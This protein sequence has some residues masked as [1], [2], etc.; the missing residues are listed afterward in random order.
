MKSA[1]K[2]PFTPLQITLTASCECS[3][4]RCEQAM[5]KVHDALVR[6]EHPIEQP[7]RVLDKL[8]VRAV[9]LGERLLV[10]A[11]HH[12]L[13][14]GPE[15][16]QAER[17]HV[18]DP[19]LPALGLLERHARLAALRMR[20]GVDAAL[21]ARVLGK[22]RGA[23]ARRGIDEVEMDEPPVPPSRVITP[24]NATS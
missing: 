12:H 24:S 14:L 16:F 8:Q 4:S 13:R 11:L 22:F 18:L 10:L 20:H 21:V 3:D 7:R 15:P 23:R 1:V 5:R 17:V 2:P 9:Q 19:D 6:V